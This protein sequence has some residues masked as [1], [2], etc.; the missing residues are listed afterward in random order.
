M[1]FL[2]KMCPCNKLCC[3][4]RINVVKNV[5]I[6]I[7]NKYNYVTLALCYSSLLTFKEPTVRQCFYNIFC[8]Q[9]MQVL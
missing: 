8:L 7:E 6:F 5:D 4:N 2:A 3:E 9:K 1:A